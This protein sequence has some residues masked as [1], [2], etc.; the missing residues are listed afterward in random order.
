MK[1]SY[2][3][4]EKLELKLDVDEWPAKFINQNAELFVTK[5]ISQSQSENIR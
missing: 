5:I 4:T 2:S 1:F 3:S